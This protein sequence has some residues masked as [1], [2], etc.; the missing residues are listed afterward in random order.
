[1]A[2]AW[3]VEREELQVLK[4]EQSKIISRLDKIEKAKDT[5]AINELKKKVDEV[6]SRV[7]TDILSK[8]EVAEESLQREARALKEERIKLEIKERQSN[9]VVRGLEMA[10]GETNESLL[11]QVDDL[12]CEL[13]VERSVQVVQVRRLIPRMSQASGRAK[14]KSYVPPVLLTLGESSQKAVLLKALPAWAKE[15]ESN[16]RIRFMPDYPPLLRPQL[17][18]LEKKAYELR[19]EKGCQTRVD[20]VKATLVLKIREKGD[21]SFSPFNISE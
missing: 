3:V 11:S 4:E 1:M 19:Q 10:S 6:S 13:K 12:L 2:E 15:R 14:S 8:L 21:K 7:P 17:E 16:K 20:I 9:F 18:I 5:K